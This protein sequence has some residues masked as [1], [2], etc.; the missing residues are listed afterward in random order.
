M[1]LLNL[2]G[3][4][5]RAQAFCLLPVSLLNVKTHSIYN[6][7][8]RFVRQHTLHVVL[9]HRLCEIRVWQPVTSVWI[10]MFDCECRF[11]PTMFLPISV[12]WLVGWLVCWLV[13]WWVGWM[14]GWMDAWMDGWWVFWMNGGLVCWLVG[15]QDYT[16]T[17]KQKLDTI[18]FGYG[19]G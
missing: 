17:T 16:K 15:H 2:V 7:S 11:T 5:W 14:D 18:N 13:C 6:M 4:S 12:S 3:P 10:R 8:G 9:L 19:S 1:A